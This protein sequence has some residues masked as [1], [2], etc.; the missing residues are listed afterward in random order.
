MFV[1]KAANS[2][3]DAIASGATEGVNPER[4]L[5]DAFR[6]VRDQIQALGDVDLLKRMEA[7]YEQVRSAHMGLGD[8]KAAND[9]LVKELE[10]AAQAAQEGIVG[11]LIDIPISK[12]GISIGPSGSTVNSSA[13][14]IIRNIMVSS[15][16]ENEIRR[17]MDKIAVLPEAQ[18]V[19]AR[20]ALQAV[21]LREIGDKIFGG[22]STTMKS[23]TQ[24]RTSV[25]Q[26]AIKKITA[27]EAGNLFKSINTVFGKDSSMSEAVTDVVNLMYQTSL[28][29]R[30]RASQSGSDTIINAA[31][32]SNI[33]DAVSSAILLTAGYMNPTAAMLR[34][35]TSVPVAEAEALQKEI[36]A[37]TLA[38]IVTDPKKFAEL[39]AATAG[40]RDPTMMQKASMLAKQAVEQ[41]AAGGRY[42]IRVQEEDAFGEEDSG[43]IDMDMLQ[44]FGAK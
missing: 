40:G 22:S 42:E 14:Q 6:P 26:G 15:N 7:A 3:R 32:D 24:A 41:A 36:A 29:S 1:S 21:A 9:T 44:L 17:L 4:A 37:H 20:D 39:L 25:A 28:P 33:R 13:K 31:R 43:P 5:L 12:P 34:R 10:N 8:V 27:D 35:I 16:S 30:I 2:L 38:V 23:G 11:Q 18:K 19:M